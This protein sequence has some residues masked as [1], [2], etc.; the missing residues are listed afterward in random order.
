MAGGLLRLR[1]ERQ[2]RKHGEEVDFEKPA[3][4]HVP[5]P[6][7]AAKIKLFL[8]PTGVKRGALQEIKVGIKRK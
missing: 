2:I 6:V 3:Q 8:H 5:G 1:G 4:N 7:H